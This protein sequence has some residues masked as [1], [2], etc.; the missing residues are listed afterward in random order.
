MRENPQEQD[1]LFKELLIGVTNFFRDP[2]A[3]EHLTTNIIPE[4]LAGYPLGKEL[5]AWVSACSTGEEAYSL[6]IAFKE[7]LANSQLPQRFRLQIF[8]TDLD[9]DA[10]DQARQ[11]FYPANIVADVSAKRLSRFVIAEDH[12]YR[13]NKEIREMVIFAKQNIALD[14]PF[15]KL[16]LL[17]CRNLLIYFG[18]ELQK[19]LIPLFH[20]ALN[21]HGILILGDAE[22]IGNFNTLFSTLDKHS[23]L[24]QRIDQTLSPISIDFPTKHASVASMTEQ[25]NTLSK[26]IANFQNL[27][28]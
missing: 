25:E 10:I 22:S 15:T 19:K 24:Y 18:P 11:G 20:Y 5:R 23:R 16:D 2:A 27:V 17:S 6:A 4:L 8:A 13:I 7:A 21:S 14:P 3:W 28:D 26:S 9:E 12:G 1:L